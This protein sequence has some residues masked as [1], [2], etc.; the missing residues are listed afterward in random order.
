[1]N[2]EEFKPDILVDAEVAGRA[3]DVAKHEVSD[4]EDDNEDEVSK[5]VSNFLLSLDDNDEGNEDTCNWFPVLLVLGL[6]NLLIIV[7]TIRP[8]Q[9]K[10]RI[11][12]KINPFKNE[13]RGD[14]KPKNIAM[15][16]II[17]E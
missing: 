8:R 3:D 10:E 17:N 9:D 2:D 6:K 7:K 11:M 13:G 15:S 16:G 5:C 4:D 14:L 1:L 12:P